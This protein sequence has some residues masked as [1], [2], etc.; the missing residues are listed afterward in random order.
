[1][2]RPTI[3]AKPAAPSIRQHIG[4]AVQRSRKVTRKLRPDEQPAS[5]AELVEDIGRKLPLSPT[6]LNLMR[7]RAKDQDE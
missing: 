1:M 7:E 2:R 5:R 3:P 4:P 6:L